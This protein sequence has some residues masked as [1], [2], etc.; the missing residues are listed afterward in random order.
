M[1][2]LWLALHLHLHLHLRFHLHLHLQAA[3][4]PGRPAIWLQLTIANAV[5]TCT[6]T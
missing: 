1:P 4:A 6:C 3:H 2:D 5:R